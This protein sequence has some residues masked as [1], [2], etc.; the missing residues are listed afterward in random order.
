MK[1]TEKI[2]GSTTNRYIEKMRARGVDPK[3]GI[4]MKR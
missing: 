1:V 3:T 2:K 4:E